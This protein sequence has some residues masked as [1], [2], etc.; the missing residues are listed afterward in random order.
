FD[1]SGFGF[2]PGEAV[3]VVQQPPPAAKPGA[4]TLAVKAPT[5]TPVVMTA[6]GQGRIQ[7]T[8]VAY[9]AHCSAIGPLQAAGYKGTYVTAP[10]GWR[11]PVMMACPAFEAPDAPTQSSASAGSLSVRVQ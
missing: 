4:A 3:R 9:V 10:L 8:I 1:V 2:V 5:A 7:G 6:D 11:D